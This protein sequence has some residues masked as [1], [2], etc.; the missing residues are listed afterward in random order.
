M[1]QGA[2]PPASLGVICPVDARGLIIGPKIGF[3]QNKRVE[4]SLLSGGMV[5]LSNAALCNNKFSAEETGSQVILETN[6][7][8][9]ETGAL[10]S[11]QGGARGSAQGSSPAIRGEGDA[12]HG[13]LEVEVVQHRPAHQAD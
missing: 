3:V 5:H 6:D 11:S 1:T 8:W 13:T 4:F 10:H 7:S 12:V 2:M 9:P